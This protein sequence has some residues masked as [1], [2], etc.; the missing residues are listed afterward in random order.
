MKSISIA[1]IVIVLTLGLETTSFGAEAHLNGPVIGVTD[2]RARALVAVFISLLSAI[3]GCLA[4]SRSLTRARKPNRRR[5]AIVSLVL[6]FAAIVLSAIH[7]ATASGPF[8]S[9]SGRAGA[10]VALL[11]G[12]TGAGLGRMALVRVNRYAGGTL[13]RPPSEESLINNDGQPAR[14]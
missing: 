1:I 11:L 5:I 13:T 2:G 7:L 9:G 10:I 4:L 6:A 3:L 12:I 14:E 8:G